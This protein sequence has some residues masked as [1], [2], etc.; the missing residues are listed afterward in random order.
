MTKLIKGAIYQHFKGNKYE[1][2]DVVRH[3]ETLEEMVLYKPLYKNK[4]FPNQ[5]WVRPLKMFTEIVEKD[6]KKIP[7]FKL[8]DRKS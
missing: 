2:I 7:R 6:G 8:L 1:V 4:E 3:S 5:L